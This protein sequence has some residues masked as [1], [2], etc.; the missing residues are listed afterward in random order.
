MVGLRIMLKTN[1]GLTESEIEEVLQAVSKSIPPC[2]FM[3]NTV[4]IPFP[5]DSVKSVLRYHR[6]KNNTDC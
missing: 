6:E 3:A 1:G 5:C 2:N 4:V